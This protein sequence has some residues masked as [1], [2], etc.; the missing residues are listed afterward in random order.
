[1]A[2]ERA[3]GGRSRGVHAKPL[4]QGGNKAGQLAL[5]VANI[6]EPRREDVVHVDDDTLRGADWHLSSGLRVEWLVSR[7][8]GS[9]LETVAAIGRS[10]GDALA[11]VGPT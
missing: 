7:A 4:P 9:R 10:C 1:M 2:L 5:H 8:R 11:L 6:V 3:L